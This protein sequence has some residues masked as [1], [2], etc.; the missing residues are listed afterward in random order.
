MLRLG[1]QDWNVL[2][3]PTYRRYYEWVLSVYK[4]K[5]R[6]GC[7]SSDAK[8]PDQNGEPCQNLWKG[9]DNA[10]SKK[11][12]GASTYKNLDIT[13]PYWSDAGFK[14]SILNMHSNGHLHLTCK[15]YCNIVSNAPRAC[16]HCMQIQ[17]PTRQNAQ[18][19]SMTMYDDIVFAAAQRGILK[20][21]MSMSMSR[22]EATRQ[23]A[24]FVKGLKYYPKDNIPLICPKQERLDDLLN[25][26][27]ALEKM[28]LPDFFES[29]EGERN[30]RDSF[31]VDKEQFCWVNVDALLEGKNSWEQVLAALK[32]TST[33]TVT[34]V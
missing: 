22:Q 24:K 12:F 28:V 6:R 9:V 31:G 30:H 27:L 10:L 32:S 20:K 13:I 4:E 5:N 2:V 14:L 26:S 1:Y 17:Q 16:Q 21:T 34:Y 3:V 18:S 33:R 29:P 19:S 7:L 23:L 11:E 15:F 8:W 25:K